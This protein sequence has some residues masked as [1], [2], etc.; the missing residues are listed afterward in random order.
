MMGAGVAP[1][2]RPGS[3]YLTGRVPPTRP[4]IPTN[5]SRAMR[6]LGTGRVRRAKA[7]DKG[8]DRIRRSGLWTPKGGSRPETDGEVR[9]KEVGP[10]GRLKWGR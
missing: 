4:M 1:P 6:P 10:D 5:R 9:E 2:P 3:A 8:E 7:N